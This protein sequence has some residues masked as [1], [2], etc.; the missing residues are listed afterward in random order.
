MRIQ[1]DET[2]RE[3]IFQRCHIDFAQLDE[4]F[5]LPYVEDQCHDDPEQYRLFGFI[6]GRLLTLI[7]ESREDT[8][9][10]VL[11]VAMAWHATAQEQRAYEQTI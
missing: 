3:Q 4:L 8:F 5:A 7:V 9:G 6:G 11:W 2:K 1:W 10:E